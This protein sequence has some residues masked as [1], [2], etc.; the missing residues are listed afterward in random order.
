[1]S[2]DRHETLDSGIDSRFG[3]RVETVQERVPGARIQDPA[4]DARLGELYSCE[5][6]DGDVPVR[7][8]VR[9]RP[10]LGG[11]SVQMPV[12]G[13][14]QELDVCIYDSDRNP[15][16]RIRLH[17]GTE[18][19]ADGSTRKVATGFLG[20]LQPGTLYGYRPVS[21]DPTIDY[22]FLLV[23]P[24]A[25]AFDGDFKAVNPDGSPNEH[26]HK[27]KVD[28][29]RDS[30][31]YVPLAMV[32]D[33]SFDWGGDTRPHTDYRD[34]VIYEAHTKGLTQL[35]PDVPPEL[36]GT[37]LGLA[38]PSMIE[39]L[40]SIGV[41][42]VELLPPM[43]FV[44]DYHLQ[45][46][47]AGRDLSGEDPG[48]VRNYWGY[49]T[50][51]FFAA[52]NAYASSD[53][54]GSAVAE[55]KTMVKALHEAGIEVILDVVYNHTPEGGPRGPVLNFKG[56]DWNGYHWFDSTG[57]GNAVNGHNPLM[58]QMILNSLEYWVREMHVDGFRCDLATTL[59]RRPDELI[60][61]ASGLI[62]AIEEHPDLQ[63]VKL[64]A[65]GWDWGS[66]DT[67]AFGP[68]WYEWNGLFRDWARGYWTAGKEGEESDESMARVL[69]GSSHK[70][71]RGPYNGSG[72]LN[73]VTGHDGYSL[74]DLVSYNWKN[75][76]PNGENN[77]DGAPNPDNRSNNFGV[78]GTIAQNYATAEGNERFVLDLRQRVARSLMLTLFLAPGV[79]MV[80]HG[81][82]ILDTR[83]GNNNPYCQDNKITWVEW[84][85]LWDWQRNFLAFMQA[86][87]LL[88]AEHRELF[89]RTAP[90]T[91]AELDGS[92]HPDIAWYA[93]NGERVGMGGEKDQEVFG[94]HR[95]LGAEMIVRSGKEGRLL[96]Y[97]LA[98]NNW[99][100]SEVQ[101]PR[102]LA[103]MRGRVLI[104]TASGEVSPDGSGREV[105]DGRFV[106]KGLSAVLLQ[107]PDIL[108][109]IS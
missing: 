53:Q 82:E 73:F 97:Y 56:L 68:R 34:T 77:R 88:R 40:K 27:G 64:I 72:S 90:Y 106:V 87:R 103:P 66:G 13:K 71:T 22:G 41:T 93:W 48:G 78:E 38:H 20:D 62:R 55:F 80:S 46:N 92:G 39:H 21:D 32:V 16:K 15:V 70:Y 7:D 12:G 85:K 2:F 49:N 57:V 14:V 36:R 4:Y 76:Y 10:D 95:I 75:N 19:F 63:D 89:H 69:P 50:V 30:A 81:D 74:R 59:A 61:T 31:P 8:G 108:H 51:G 84:N 23:D 26:V 45:Q 3:Y 37:Y 29:W 98:T 91:G 5:T 83:Y 65:E 9:F 11:S 104:D 35:H 28:G 24:Y 102:H 6:L 60:D 42:A 107:L 58:Q 101:L 100:Q 105:T 79:P 99:A 33:E 94:R 52:H 18:E 43:Q 44:H 109:D 47:A 17:T 1:M 54:P 86:F 25:L 67:G 96:R